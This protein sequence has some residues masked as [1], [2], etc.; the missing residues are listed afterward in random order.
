MLDVIHADHRVVAHFQRE[1][2]LVDFGAR[3]GV[4]RFLGV[5]RDDIV[6]ESRAVDF[7]EGD[8]EAAGD[9]F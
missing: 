9:V 4:R 2:E 1:V 8:A 6:S 3:G 7:D 5:E